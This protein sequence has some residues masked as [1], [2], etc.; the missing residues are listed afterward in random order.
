MALTSLLGIQYAEKNLRF[1]LAAPDG[2]T[3]FD[4]EDMLELIGNLADNACKWARSQ[5]GIKVECLQGNFCVTVDDDGPGC[6]DEDLAELTQR[7]LRLDEAP[8]GHGLGLSIVS[9]IVGFYGGS[10]EL[11]RS[12]ILGGLRVT[13]RF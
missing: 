3:P 7:G 4:R 11:G 13:V 9:D 2:S 8:P 10:L 5:V 6:P 12:P 1:E